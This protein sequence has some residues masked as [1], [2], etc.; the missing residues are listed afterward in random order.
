SFALRTSYAWGSGGCGAS[1]LWGTSCGPPG[2][3]SRAPRPPR[4][5]GA[6]NPP[7]KRFRTETRSQHKPKPTPDRD[8]NY[9]PCRPEH[10]GK[11]GTLVQRKEIHADRDGDVDEEAGVDAPRSHRERAEHHAG[12]DR[13]LGFEIGLSVVDHAVGHGHRED[14]ARA[15]GA[16]ECA[17]HPP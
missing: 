12:D 6:S 4:G 8:A 17:D 1:E 2:L 11:R 13:A 7:A 16:T 9:S 14:G 10:D 15:H 3:R 5:R